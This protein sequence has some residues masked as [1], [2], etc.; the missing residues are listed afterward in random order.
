M[1]S[2]SPTPSSCLVKSFFA[3]AEYSLAVLAARQ[4]VYHKDKVATAQKDELSRRDNG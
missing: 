1:G 3:P 2:G 4:L